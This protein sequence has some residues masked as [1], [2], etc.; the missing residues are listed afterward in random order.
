MLED[1]LIKGLFWGLSLFTEPRN[2]TKE[3]EFKV[4]LGELMLRSLKCCSFVHLDLAL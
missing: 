1:S 4:P 2:Q 3:S